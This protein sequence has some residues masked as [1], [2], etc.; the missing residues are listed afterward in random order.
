[1]SLYAFNDA[2]LKNTG[3]EVAAGEAISTVGSSGG[4]GRPAL[5]FELRHN[6]Q[7]ADPGAWLRK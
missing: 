4:Q 5:Y 6:G 3:D 2:L 1:M 7:P